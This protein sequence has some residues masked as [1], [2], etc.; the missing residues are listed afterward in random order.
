[1][2]IMIV[3]D[4]HLIRAGL[5]EQ[6][7]QWFESASVLQADCARDA[8][9]QLESTEQLDLALIDLYMPDGDGF[10]FIRKLCNLYSDLPVLVLSSSQNP[11]D[12]RKALGMG[13]SG[14][15]TKASSSEEIFCCVFIPT[16]PPT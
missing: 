3:D 7:C 2:K 4:H 5:K 6:L 8:L 15:V 13:A 1:M 10:T 12:I 16:F 11:A 14:Y 9:Q